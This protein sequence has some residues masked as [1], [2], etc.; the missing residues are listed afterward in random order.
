MKKLTMLIAGLVFCA[1]PALMVAQDSG[2]NSAEKPEAKFYKLNFT[3]EELNDAGRVVNSR[4]Y[5]ATIVTGPGSSQQIR[6]GSRVPIA[7]GAQNGST[8]F[9][10][11]DVGVN[12]DVR[13][14]KEL[15][16]KLG[17]YLVAEISSL[18]PQPSGAP[19][20]IAADPIIRQNKWDSM[21]TIPV[22]KPTVVFS[23]DN[24]EDKGKMQVE[25]TATRI[26]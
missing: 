17:F 8:Q 25:L 23:A 4:A 5:V 22:G 7:T 12:F 10:Y 11:V 14:V 18:A 6:T 24:L 15:G 16:D 2:Q 26:E 9:Q 20:T 1:L 13:Q 19:P 3:L 21:V